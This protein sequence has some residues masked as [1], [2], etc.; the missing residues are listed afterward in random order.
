M[1]GSPFGTVR[2]M[3]RRLASRPRRRVSPSH[4]ARASTQAGR[5]GSRTRESPRGRRRP[6]FH[7]TRRAVSARRGAWTLG[8]SDCKAAF[9]F[10]S[11]F[12]VA[13]AS[14]VLS[15]LD[16]LSGCVGCVTASVGDV[17]GLAPPRG[18]PE[19]PCLVRRLPERENGFDLSP[20]SNAFKPRLR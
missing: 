3:L 13:A 11:I 6:S 15:P 19:L 18:F 5:R 10:S 1:P 17:H 14:L 7:H 8:D 20:T 16:E 2:V 9:Q 4:P 12:F